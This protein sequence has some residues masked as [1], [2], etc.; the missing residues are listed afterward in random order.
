MRVVRLV[1]PT[2]RNRWLRHAA[3]NALTQSQQGSWEAG[4]VEQVE[5]G[6]FEVFGK[7]VWDID[8]YIY[9][10]FRTPKTMVFLVV[11]LKGGA[12]S[13]SDPAG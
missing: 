4:H 6:A 8:I 10:F 7:R 13:K 12:L 9:L 11:S 2:G 3:E 5:P 1:L